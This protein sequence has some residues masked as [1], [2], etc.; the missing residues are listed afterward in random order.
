MIARTL[1]LGALLTVAAVLQTTL[2]P[3][4]GLT[5]FRPDLLLLVVLAV[6]LHDGPIAGVRVGASAGLLTDLLLL[7]SPVGLVTLVMAV[8]GFMVGSIRPYLA[9]DSITAPVLLTFAASTMGTFVVGLLALLLG[10]DRST[11]ALLG[12]A[13]LGVGFAT[14]LLAPVTIRPLRGLLDR[15]PVRG[16]AVSEDD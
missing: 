16:A 8:I 6:A 13:S 14:T 2:L 10:D 11:L 15:Y 3:L 12:Q 4:L 7:S 1:L 9:S 5:G